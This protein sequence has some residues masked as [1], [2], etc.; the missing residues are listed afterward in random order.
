[1]SD[2]ILRALVGQGAE[3]MDVHGMSDIILRAL[4]GQG[5]EYMDVHG[6]SD[7]ILR[8]LVGQ[9]AEYMDVHGM[10]DVTVCLCVSVI[11]YNSGVCCVVGPAVVDVSKHR[12]AF[13]VKV[14]WP[15]NIS[16]T[17]AARTSKLTAVCCRYCR[18]MRTDGRTHKPVPVG[19]Q[20]DTP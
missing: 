6:M 3:Y 18:T 8:A 17:T 10:S 13:I 2:I 14:K 11:T 4:V 16:T 19:P 7:I 9:G 1:M 5:A 20:V 15:D 12:T